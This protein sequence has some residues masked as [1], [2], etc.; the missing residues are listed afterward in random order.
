[1]KKIKLKR[2]E[3]LSFKVA[4][5]LP[6]KKGL[7]AVMKKR[8]IRLYLG[9]DP[10]GGNLHL[11]HAI[12]LRKLQQFADLGHEA[13]L[14][15]G[16][17]TVLAGDPSQRDTARIKITKKEIEK[18]TKSWKKQAAKLIDFS[19]VKLR[20]NGDWLLKL[21]L[22]DIL[23]IA[24]NISAV[25]LF[26][27]DMFQRRLAKGD[28]VWMHETLYP[29][30]QGYDSVAL[31]VDLEIGGTDQVFNMLIGRELERKMKNKEKFVLTVPMILGLDGKTMSKTSGNT[32]NITDSPKEMYGKLMTLR[33]ELVAQ[34]FELATDV[35]KKEVLLF[36]RKLSPRDFK[37]RLAREITAFYHTKAKAQAAQKE[38]VKVFQKKQLPSHIQKAKVRSKASRPLYKAVAEMFFV[39][40]AEARRVIEQGGVKI[41]S[42]VQKDP[43]LIFKL[44]S[45]TIIQIGKRRIL[46][47]A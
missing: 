46:K 2:A 1:M 15:V 24:S 9:I 35:P 25:Q 18:N 42:V 11:G 8:K 32:V 12:A 4:E 44:R 21:K 37:A 34:Y 6:D 17:G 10:T 19:K 3:V 14:L 16:T 13:I 26:S 38:F 28:T 30:L 29:L 33:D 7:A 45:G 27:R 40:G 20:Y 23:E 31:N 47:I 36:K 22:A 41:D 39:S 5:I 43:N